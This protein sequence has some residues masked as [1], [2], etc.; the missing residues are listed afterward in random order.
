MLWCFIII[1]LHMVVTIGVLIE[2]NVQFNC[3]ELTTSLIV[4]SPWLMFSF[5][6]LQIR[7]LFLGIFFPLAMQYLI[8]VVFNHCTFI[9]HKNLPKVCFSL[10]HPYDKLF[11]NLPLLP[12]IL[13]LKYTTQTESIWQHWM[14][15]YWLLMGGDLHPSLQSKRRILT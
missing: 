13:I 8:K 10:S 1:L 6:F 5:I 15:F 12:M 11:H 7:I 9:S 14:L 3:R 4:S 2:L